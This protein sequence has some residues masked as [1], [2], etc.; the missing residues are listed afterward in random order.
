MIGVTFISYAKTMENE[1]VRHSDHRKRTAKFSHRCSKRALVLI[2]P[3]T[4]ACASIEGKTQYRED[5]TKVRSQSVLLVYFTC[6]LI[7]HRIAP[8][9]GLIALEFAIRPKA[10][11]REDDFTDLAANDM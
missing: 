4:T 3:P 10:T 6:Y 9:N 1:I 8:D 2:C 5:F 7:R 11:F